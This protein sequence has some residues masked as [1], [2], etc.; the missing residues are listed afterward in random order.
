MPIKANNMC[1]TSKLE[2]VFTTFKC[3]GK[4]TTHRIYCQFLLIYLLL[5][6]NNFQDT[7]L[8]METACQ[9]KQLAFGGWKAHSISALRLV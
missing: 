4:Y 8:A 6:I 2:R 1:I 3:A 5:M 7:K 9:I